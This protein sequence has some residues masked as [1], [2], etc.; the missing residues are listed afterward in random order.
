MHTQQILAASLEMN[1]K[2]EER[3]IDPSKIKSLL[4]KKLSTSQ[5]TNP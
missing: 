1:T 4:S 3:I 5:L 2:I